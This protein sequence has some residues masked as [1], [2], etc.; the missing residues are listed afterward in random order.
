MPSETKSS[1]TAPPEAAERPSA[2]RAAARAL[3]EVHILKRWVQIGVYSS[4]FGLAPVNHYLV[5]LSVGELLYVLATSIV[6]ATT[7]IEWAFGQMHKLRKRS[8]LPGAV[9]MEMGTL[10]L[11]EAEEHS[12]DIVRDLLGLT[13]SMLVLQEN[14]SEM[15]V[16]SSSGLDESQT[17]QLFE[18]IKP[19]IR[20]C[21]E[22]QRLLRRS[23]KEAGQKPSE[24]GRRAVFIP[25]I[26]LRQPIGAIVGITDRPAQVSDQELLASIG[27]A[28]GLSLE[29]LRQQEEIHRSEK[30]FRSLIENAS[31]IIAVIGN[32]GVYRYVSPS[33]ERVLGYK[34]EELVGKDPR[35]FVHPDDFRLIAEA[36]QEGSQTQGPTEPIEVRAPHK[37]GSWRVLEAIAEDL[38][39]DPAVGAIVVNTRDITERKKVEESLTEAEARNRALLNAM[40]D[41]IIRVRKDG[42]VLD[43][44]APNEFPFM[45]P[46]PEYIGRNLFDVLS[47]EVGEKARHYLK[48]T[49]D[50][51]ELQTFEYEIE[52][53]GEKFVREARVVV[54]GPDEALA[55]IRDVTESRRAQEELVSLSSAVKMSIDGIVVTDL[56]GT[57][58]EANEAAL[59]TKSPGNPATSS[60]RT[61]STSS[62]PRRG[63]ARSPECARSWRKAS[64]ATGSTTS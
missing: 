64:F 41:G 34:P 19:D 28:L 10:R 62:S 25:L 38:R 59:S 23:L 21:I 37:D 52:I 35:A 51:G 6:I 55:I 54:S 44:V 30:Y 43:M 18:A 29:N 3:R 12:A 48:R 17:A 16:A 32:D 42:T 53:N 36:L 11:S 1:E 20:E 15:R 27:S 46:P 4:I 22:G 40:P 24:S 57:I 58:L 56:Q 47:P 45:I 2:A 61:P 39:D 5:G 31:D 50:T 63:N 49:L 60:A 8:A 9:L 13:S 7:A 33:V 26:A 14:G